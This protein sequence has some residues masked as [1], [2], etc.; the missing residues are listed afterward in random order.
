MA[1]DEEGKPVDARNSTQPQSSAR[2]ESPPLWQD[3]QLQQEIMAAKGIELHV[4]KE[5]KGKG[6]GKGRGMH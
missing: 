5:R 1:R 4:A 6:K 2:A 3:Q